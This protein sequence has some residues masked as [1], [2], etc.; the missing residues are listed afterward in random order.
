[1]MELREKLK[2]KAHENM[3]N[4]SSYSLSPDDALQIFA[5]WLESGE[6]MTVVSDAVMKAL[7]AGDPVASA[8]CTAL[9]RTIRG[10]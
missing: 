2:A 9:S 8:G 1:M 7:M 10:E 6:A 3:R 5:E 4:S